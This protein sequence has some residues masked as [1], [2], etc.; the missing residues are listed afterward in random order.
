MP[1]VVYD[2]YKSDQEFG[3]VVGCLRNKR[4]DQKILC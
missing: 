2:C 1:T 3:G 4:I